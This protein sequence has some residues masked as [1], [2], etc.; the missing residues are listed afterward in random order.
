MSA[1][2]FRWPSVRSPQELTATV[3]SRTLRHYVWSD[4]L[5][6]GYFGEVSP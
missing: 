1:R 4:H 5:T 3:A 6:R 2:I